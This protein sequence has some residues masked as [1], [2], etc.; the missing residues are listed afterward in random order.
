MKKGIE[1]NEQLK[2]SESNLIILNQNTLNLAFKIQGMIYKLN[3]SLNT[4]VVIIWQGTSVTVTKGRHFS[5]FRQSPMF[6]VTHGQG[7]EVMLL[8]NV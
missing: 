6:M 3:A 1:N 8:T 2:L 5:R 7:C 4:T